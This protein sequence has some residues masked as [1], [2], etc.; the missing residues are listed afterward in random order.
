MIIDTTQTALEHKIKSKIQLVNLIADLNQLYPKR[1]PYAG[2]ARTVVCLYGV[3]TCVTVDVWQRETGLKF[4]WGNLT[5]ADGE[6]P[7]RMAKSELNSNCN[8]LSSQIKWLITNIKN[9]LIKQNKVVQKSERSS[10]LLT[11]P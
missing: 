3:V 8:E 1:K 2:L 6:I 4:N 11:V 5:G 7:L 9:R 10:H